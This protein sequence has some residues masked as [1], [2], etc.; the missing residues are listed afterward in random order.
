MTILADFLFSISSQNELGEG[1]I[2]DNLTQTIWWTDIQASTIFQFDVVA[3]EVVAHDMPER[4]GCFGFT[5]F[6]DVLIVAFA[7]GFALY[8]LMTKQTQ[9]LAQPEI[10]IEG[11]RFNDGK[12]DRHGNFWAGT[13][14]EHRKTPEQTGSL[15]CLDSDFECHKKLTGIE[16]SNSLCFSHH[17]ELLYHGDSQANCVY[18][19]HLA[20]DG[21]R[22]SNQL[23]RKKA[24]INTAQDVFP[25]GACVDEDGNV[26][27]AQW[28]GSQVVCYSPEGEVL[29]TIPTPVSQPT[30]VAFGGPNLDWLIVTS[31][32]ESLSADDLNLQPQAGDVFI[33]QVK[34][35]RG[36]VE[37]RFNL[38]QHFS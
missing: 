22:E 3:R 34:G 28:G 24:L 20:C 33:Y 37:P 21:Q 17:C 35:I 36:L 9:W 30:C 26:W 32:K 18:Q 11:N 14:V 12:V 13:L 4:V 25:D 19:Y 5:N 6:D 29:L 23:T 7:S 27:S 1:V 15:Y 16:I 8:N 2:W 31:A 38:A 10:N